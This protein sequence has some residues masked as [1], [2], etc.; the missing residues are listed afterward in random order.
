MASL[1]P[2]TKTKTKKTI[3]SRQ[4]AIPNTKKTNSRQDITKTSVMDVAD[5]WMAHYSGQMATPPK[6]LASRVKQASA[7]METMVRQGLPVAVA[8]RLTPDAFHTLHS[9]RYSYT[10]NDASQWNKY[11]R[12]CILWK[13]RGENDNFRFGLAIKGFVHILVP[14]QS[15]IQKTDALIVLHHYRHGSRRKPHMYALLY[16]KKRRPQQGVPTMNDRSAQYS[17]FPKNTDWDMALV[18]NLVEDACQKP[19]DRLPIVIPTRAF[20]DERE[21]DGFHLPRG[22]TLHFMADSNAPW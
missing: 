10:E 12:K 16:L 1:P 22:A 15:V 17:M 6:D 4:A 18:A 8:Q 13:A 5:T 21:R 2:T 14:G 3:L 9:N 7:W 19:A 11:P 20:Q